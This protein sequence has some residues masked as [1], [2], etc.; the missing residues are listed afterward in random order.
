MIRPIVKY[1]DPIL[2][3]PTEPVTEFNDELRQLVDDMFESMYDA[4][5]IGLAAPQIG[6]AKR[7]T[8][9]DLSFKEDPE[10][11]IVL[12]NPEIIHREGKQYEEEGCLSLPDIREKVSRAA[13]VTVKAQDV[14]GEWFEI[15]GEE[16]LARAFQHEID[17]L[18]GVLFFRRVSAL[19][20]DLILRRIR[21]LQ[22]AGDW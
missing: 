20:R 12:I 17:H 13:K 19:K 1:P 7:L 5:G 18:D 21:K 4:K 3:Q 6:V 10:D 16:L 9:I 22:K 14:N 15:D 8:V 2:E 11:K